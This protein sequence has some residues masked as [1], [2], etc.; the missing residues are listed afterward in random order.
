MMVIQ[1]GTVTSLKWVYWHVQR[2]LQIVIYIIRTFNTRALFLHRG[3]WI[4]TSSSDLV[5]L[6]PDFFCCFRNFLLNSRVWRGT[7]WQRKNK[8]NLLS[9]SFYFSELCI[10]WVLS[11]CGNLSQCMF[12]QSFNPITEYFQQHLESGY[13][14]TS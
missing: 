7:C 4:V 12:D 9:V 5:N 6:S 11:L 14:R 8:W 13:V 1:T 2:F 10:S 3:E